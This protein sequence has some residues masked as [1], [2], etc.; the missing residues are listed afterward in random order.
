VLA[1]KIIHISELDDKPLD[2]SCPICL[3]PFSAVI[4]EEEM[5]DAMSS[6]AY[7]A[8]DLGV[9]RLKNVV[10]SEEG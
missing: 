10:E 2:S 3:T 7:A 1:R 5:A 4:A 9:T 6:P 8:Q